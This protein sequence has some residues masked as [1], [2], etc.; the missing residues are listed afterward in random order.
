[1]RRAW[2]E[3]V[4][5]VEE[6]GLGRGELG[7]WPG[8]EEEGETGGEVEVERKARKMEVL[9]AIERGAAQDE[10]EEGER[11]RNN[12]EDD[13]DSFVEAERTHVDASTR[14][15]LNAAVAHSPHLP[16]P[17]QPYRSPPTAPNP[18]SASPPRPPSAVAPRPFSS[19]APH[20][21]S[22]PYAANLSSD[23]FGFRDLA[24]SLAASPP[25]NTPSPL[26]LQPD[27]ST[28]VSAARP[29][30]RDVNSRTAARP[31][32]D[33]A[34]QLDPLDA[35]AV[36]RLAGF[37]A[38]KADSTV[39]T[40]S[41]STALSRFLATRGITASAPS[42]STA[43]SNPSAPA[44]AQ[45]APSPHSS[46]P[47]GAIPFTLPPFLSAP[48][49]ALS[50]S[51]ASVSPSHPLRIIAFDA[52][53]QLRPHLAALVSAGFLPVHR[54]SRFPTSL[55]VTHEPHLILDAKTAVWFV[56]LVE[57]ISNAVRPDE[58]TSLTVSRQRKEAVFTTL[59][60]LS[61]RFDRL[62]LVLEESS[63]FVGGRKTYAYTPPV[64]AGLQALA[65]ALAGGL[66][67]EGGEGWETVKVRGR[68]EVALS[69]GP[70]GSAEVVRRLMESLAATATAEGEEGEG[71]GW[72][73]REWLR[74][75]PTTVRFSLSLSIF[76]R[77]RH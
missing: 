4:R 55:Y 67:G 30:P 39:A 25:R 37:K 1:M 22:E 73:E 49:S 71:N 63:T 43:S 9:A 51:R 35:L 14:Q 41:H 17:P 42:R 45:R 26:P 6:E 15:D 19:P 52:L 24:S 66:G 58:T 74:D 44:P 2:E 40:S 12:V 60:R 33:E 21:S 8:G 76:R 65:T 20:A 72:G 68:V 46:P 70:E 53:F 59:V 13:V 11:P 61:Y 54:P 34:A 47:P 38:E 23:S 57:L 64:L 5:E 75:D 56:P 10:M 77:K 50:P 28:G 32:A 62:L 18:P 3:G 27:V 16:S 31:P 69:K 7:V 48:S 29:A 36:E